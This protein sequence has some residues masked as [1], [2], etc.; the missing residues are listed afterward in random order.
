MSIFKTV[1]VF[2]TLLMFAT[3][4]RVS[5]ATVLD[6]EALPSG[7]TPTSYWQ[8]SLSST[9]SR[10]TTQYLDLGVV[11][12]NAAVSNLGAGHTASG[13]NGLSPINAG[14]FIDY[15]AIVEFSFFA[16]SDGV[17]KATTNFFGYAPDL[18]GGSGNIVTITAYG[19]DGAVVGSKS[20]LETGTFYSPLEINGIG[21]FHSVT[22]DQ[23]LYD[24]FSG[25]IGIDLVRYGDLT[26]SKVPEPSA[27]ALFIF[28]FAA[29][30][31]SRRRVDSLQATA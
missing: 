2:A 4:G 12:S 23:T 9:S 1:Q 13:S 28:G 5:G 31:I 22:I 3:V 10:V 8:G 29:L 16:P 17:T 11:I 15:D 19:L 14:G 18:G 6:F 20:W 25:G 30:G 24:T 21:E 26:P 7:V 27:I